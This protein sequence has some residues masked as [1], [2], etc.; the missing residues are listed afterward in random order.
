MPYNP[1]APMDVQIKTSIASSLHNLRHETE[2]SNSSYIDALLLHS[3]FPTIDEN[4]QAWKLLESYVPHQIR[5]LG[6]SNVT[7]PILQAI[8]DNSTIKP[9]MVSNRFYADTRYDVP[10]RAFCREYGIA[11]QSFWTLTC[12]PDLVRSAPVDGL[13][14]AVNVQRAGA[15]Y[16]LVSALDI[17][18]LNGTTSKKHMRDDLDDVKKVQE[19]ASQN[20]DQW[21]GMTDAFRQLIGDDRA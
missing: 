11:Y 16:A 12:N 9:T 8:Y 6:I 2:S 18:I 5:T 7:F 4:L 15:F 20:A 1:T 3:P 21:A 13:M 17:E 10:L 19:W 14:K